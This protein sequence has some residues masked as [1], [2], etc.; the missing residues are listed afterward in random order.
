MVSELSWWQVITIA[1]FDLK[2]A[3]VNDIY[4]H[5]IIKV[6]E[7][8]SDSNTI[9]HTIWGQLQRHT[10]LDCPN[11]N[12]WERSEPLYFSKDEN[13]NWTINH[14]LL[15]QYYPEAL[16]ILKSIQNFTGNEGIVVKNY[17]FVTFHQSFSYEDFIEGIKPKLEDGETELGFEIKDGVFKNFA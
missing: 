6:K 4:N 7:K 2:T 17:D 11:V 12:A 8:L 16:D 10:I 5:K 3:K 13:S 1:V 15:D 9:R 14:E